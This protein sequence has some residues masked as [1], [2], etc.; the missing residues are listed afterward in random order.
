MR[1]AA[2][3]ASVRIISSAVAVMPLAMKRKVNERERVDAETHPLHRLMTRKP[4]RWQTPKEWRQLMQAWCLLQGNA[5]SYR[6]PGVKGS[7]IELIPLNAA[8]MSVRQNADL[9]ITYR[10]Q[11]PD[12]SWREYSQS[13]IFHLRGMSLDGFTGLSPISYARE[14]IGL[15]SEAERHG[16]SF[17]KNGT[18]VG[19]V[20][21]APAGVRLDEQAQGRLRDGLEKFRG[22]GNA[23]KALVLEQGITFQKMGMSQV[24]AQFIETRKFQRSDIAMFFG[25]PPH[26]IGDTEKSTSWGTGIEQQ[27]LGFQAYTLEDWLTAWE[28]AAAAQLLRDE[29]S[30]LYFRFNRAALVRGDIAA[31]YSAYATGTTNG[32]LTVNECRA[33]EELPPVP[34][35]DVARTPLNTAPLGESTNVAP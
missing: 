5:Y 14:S 7:T 16:G 30:D 6:V 35:G 9:S 21:Q 23:H 28:Q 2:V 13:E 19:S 32:I 8:R 20:L 31:R 4:N 10:Y 15:A 1:Q 25:V 18:N 11:M 27:Q 22:A 29:E 17:Y 26:M 24:D 3:F 34:G 12:G 33:F